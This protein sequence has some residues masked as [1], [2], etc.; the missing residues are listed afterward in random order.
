M[1][2]SL[3]WSHNVAPWVSL[4]QCS[5][6]RVALGAY[7]NSYLHTSHRLPVLKLRFHLKIHRWKLEDYFPFGSY[8]S[9]RRYPY[10]P[11]ISS[12][13]SNQQPRVSHSVFCCRPSGISLGLHI[14]WI[15]RLGCLR[16]GCIKAKGLIDHRH[17]LR[18][19]KSG[20]LGAQW[21]AFNYSLSAYYRRYW[22]NFSKEV[23]DIHKNWSP[24]QIEEFYSLAMPKQRQLIYYH[25]IPYATRIL[26]QASESEL[27]EPFRYTKPR[28][29]VNR[30]GHAT[31]AHSWS[32]SWPYV[33][34]RWWIFKEL[35]SLG[36]WVR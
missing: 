35:C 3:R 30:L 27:Q 14:C 18:E 25:I 22:L 34:A 12:N 19:V 31:T 16:T 2:R 17:V 8:V 29:I 9:F 6:P 26:S 5:W 4:S 36:R 20:A 23:G 32:I 21:K 24:V 11:A 1:Q 7:H 10:L 33:K 15:H 13:H 28:S